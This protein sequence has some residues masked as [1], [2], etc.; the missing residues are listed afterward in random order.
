MVL[1]LVDGGHLLGQDDRSTVSVKRE[2]TGMP[3]QD[4]PI[5]AKPPP[6]LARTLERSSR[7]R[8]NGVSDLQQRVRSSPILRDR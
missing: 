7:S 1:P 8:G 2:A 3:P 5:P 4:G 6:P